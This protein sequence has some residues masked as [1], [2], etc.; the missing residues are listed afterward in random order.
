MVDLEGYEICALIYPKGVQWDLDR[1]SEKASPVFER[2]LGQSTSV[3]A[4]MC[5]WSNYPAGSHTKEAFTG[6]PPNPDAS[7]RLPDCK[8]RFITP[9]NSFPQV[10][11]PM[12][13]SS[14]PLQSMLRILWRDVWLV[15]GCTSMESQVF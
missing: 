11:S 2:Q 3:Q 9:K 13:V 6:H 10:H 4:S 12:T 1:G 5:E 15:S 14:P 7:I 8:A